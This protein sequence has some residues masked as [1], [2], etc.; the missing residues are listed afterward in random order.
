MRGGQGC[1][2]GG[3]ASALQQAGNGGPAGCEG[4]GSVSV[5]EEGEGMK[6]GGARMKG[7]VQRWQLLL[8]GLSIRR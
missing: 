4:L 5:G 7:G 8:V 6:K 3:Q 2:G 1:P